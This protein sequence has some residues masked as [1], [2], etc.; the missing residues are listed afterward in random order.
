VLRLQVTWRQKVDRLPIDQHLLVALVAPRA[1]MDN[2]GTKDAWTN[3]EGAEI[4]NL[5]GKKVYRFLNAAD[6]LNFRHRPVGHVPSTDDLLDYADYVFFGKKLPEE[7]GKS[8]YKG[9]TKAFSWD[10]PK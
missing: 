8:T 7:F 2:E 4:A 5:A 3:P 6:K 10:V 9:E 1:L